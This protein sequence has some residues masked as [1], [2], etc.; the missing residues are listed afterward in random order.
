MVET[1]VLFNLVNSLKRFDLPVR[2]SYFQVITAII[3][4]GAPAHFANA[5]LFII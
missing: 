3:K 4:S 1:G 5:V 2:E